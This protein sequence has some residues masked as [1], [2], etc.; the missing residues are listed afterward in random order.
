[1]VLLNF[2]VH[3]LHE[4]YGPTVAGKALSVLGR[5]FTNYIMMTAFTCGMDDLRLTDEGTLGEKIY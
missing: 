2:I 3:S 4:V 5:L 1:M